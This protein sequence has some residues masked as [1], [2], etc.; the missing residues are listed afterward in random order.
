MAVLDCDMTL[1]L[2]AV[3]AAVVNVVVKLVD[4][5]VV[6]TTVVVATSL[7][8]TSKVNESCVSHSVSLRYSWLVSL[9]SFFDL[10]LYS[11]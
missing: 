1:V 9:S 8:M 10:L 11:L 2:V 4:T 7:G 5:A 6:V 3:L